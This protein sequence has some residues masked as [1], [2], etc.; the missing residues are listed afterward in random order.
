MR[1]KRNVRL[2]AI[3]VI[4]LIGIAMIVAPWATLSVIVIVYLATV[5]LSILRYAAVKRRLQGVRGAG[6]G[7]RCPPTQPSDLNPT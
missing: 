5:P 2:E 4:V 6:C 1:L 7:V 3:L